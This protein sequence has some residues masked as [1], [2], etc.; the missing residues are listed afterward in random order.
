ME[1]REIVKALT[2]ELNAFKAAYISLEGDMNNLE[3]ELENLKQ[4][5]EQEKNE[6]KTQVRVRHRRH[7]PI[8]VSLRL[9]T[10]SGISRYLSY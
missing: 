6:L 1:T 9:D 7:D 4:E 5:T 10:T 3:E 8:F 2:S